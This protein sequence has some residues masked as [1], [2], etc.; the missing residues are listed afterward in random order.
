M[1]IDDVEVMAH[2][3]SNLPE[4][5]NNIVENFEDELDGDIYPSTIKNPRDKLLYNYD[6]MNSKYNKKRKKPREGVV[7]N[8]IQGNM[9]LMWYT[10]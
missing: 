7:Q 6:R 1:N 4:E 5:H 10:W 3:L 9:Q 8:P 2:I